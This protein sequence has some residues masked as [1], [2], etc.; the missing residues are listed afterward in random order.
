MKKVNCSRCKTKTDK[1][2]LWKVD[3][4]L[5]CPECYGKGKGLKYHTIGQGVK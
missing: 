4:F 1:E 5:L 3:N 2:K